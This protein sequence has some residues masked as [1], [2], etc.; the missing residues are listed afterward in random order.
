MAAKRTRSEAAYDSNE[1]KKSKCVHAMARADDTLSANG[2]TVLRR[3]APYGQQIFAS[4]VVGDR[5]YFA[6][7]RSRV[8]TL[9]CGSLDYAVDHQFSKTDPDEAVAEFFLIVS[10]KETTDAP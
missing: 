5:T 6:E 10:R 4:L 7:I 3:H 8:A 9:R 2:W 1:S